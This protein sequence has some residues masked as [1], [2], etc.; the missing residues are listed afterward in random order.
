MSASAHS[1]GV[2]SVY[3]TILLLTCCVYLSSSQLVVV[4]GYKRHGAANKLRIQRSG[5]TGARQFFTHLYGYDCRQHYTVVVVVV[6]VVTASYT[7]AT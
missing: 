3:S 6:V 5:S 2:V 1:F 7:V 4:R